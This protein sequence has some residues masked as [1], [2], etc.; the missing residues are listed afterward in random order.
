[1]IYDACNHKTLT[2]DMVLAL[3]GPRG[4]V[5]EDFMTFDFFPGTDYEASVTMLSRCMETLILPVG[6]AGTG[7]ANNSGKIVRCAIGHCTFKIL[8][9]ATFCCTFRICLGR[10]YS[11]LLR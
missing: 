1:M 6:P 3:E 4:Y 5:I 8:Y 10:S 9:F 7:G 11:V 2:N